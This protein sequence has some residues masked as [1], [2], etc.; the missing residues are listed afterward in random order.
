MRLNRTYQCYEC[1]PL[2]TWAQTLQREQQVRVPWAR[3]GLF[4]VEHQKRR[5]CGGE[6]AGRGTRRPD[7]SRALET[8]VGSYPQ[9]NGQ[10]REGQKGWR[11]LEHSQEGQEVWSRVRAIFL[12]HLPWGFVTLVLTR[13]PEPPAPEAGSQ[14]GGCR[15]CKAN[16]NL[17]LVQKPEPLSVPAVREAGE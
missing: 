11:L 17:R 4:M 13:S 16:G 10:P 12:L 3:N 8:P 7:C 14:V 9:S 15:G 1:R 5:W 6:K 2:D